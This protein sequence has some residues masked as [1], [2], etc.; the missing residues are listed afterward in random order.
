MRLKLVCIAAVL[1]T[2]LLIGGKFAAADEASELCGLSQ[3]RIT[4]YQERISPFAEMIRATLKSFNVDER[5]IWLA[6][7]ESGGNSEATSH[8]GASGLW[9]LTAATARHY[10]C[11][12]RNDAS[13]STEA[14]AKYLA[15]LCNDFDGDIWKVI[16]AYNMGGTNYRKQGKPTN[17]AKRLADT[18]TCLMENANYAS[19]NG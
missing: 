13:A 3:N 5:F 9:Q 15:K 18:V 4:A 12:D 16:V 8:R 10:G 19:Y 17:E 6:M 11:L 14:A 2:C 1:L 7:V